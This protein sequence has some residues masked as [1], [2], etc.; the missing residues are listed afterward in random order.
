MMKR[1]F[2]PIAMEEFKSY[3]SIRNKSSRVTK[4]SPLTADKFAR[5]KLSADDYV[6]M[7]RYQIQ[8]RD[9]FIE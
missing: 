3:M 8:Q 2:Q 5:L 1:Y 4:S 9:H 7:S 6:W